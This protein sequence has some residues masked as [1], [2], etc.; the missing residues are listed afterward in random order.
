MK[1]VIEFQLEGGPVLVE[2]D[3]TSAA[4]GMGPV[5]IGDGI[6]RKTQAKLEEAL[7]GVKPF[8]EA[9]I[10]RLETLSRRPDEISVEFGFKIGA[11]GS[12]VIASTAV[13]G[14]CHVTLTWSGGG[15]GPAQ[16]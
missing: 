13:E 1:H 8:A 10:A 9:V 5:G 15:S 4:G 2:V 11:N 3:D 16:A 14:H 12:L 6:V 7:D